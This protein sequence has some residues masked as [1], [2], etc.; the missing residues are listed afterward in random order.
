MEHSQVRFMY[1]PKKEN[2]NQWQSDYVD[3]SAYISYNSTESIT[4]QQDAGEIPFAMKDFYSGYGTYDSDDKTFTITDYT[5]VTNKYRWFTI[6]D[7]NYN[8]FRIESN[9]GTVITLST[10]YTFTAEPVTGRIKIILP[11]FSMDDII[12]I[13]MWKTDGN[14]VVP[15]DVANRLS[16]IGQIVSRKRNFTEQGNRWLLKLG[17][18]SELL[19]KDINISSY[20]IGGGFPKFYQKIQNIVALSNIAN[21]NTI[22]LQWDSNNPILKKDGIT[23]FPDI[24]YT[25]DS[26]SAWDKINELCQDK[27]TGDGEYYFYILPEEDTTNGYI[28]YLRAKTFEPD[29][30]LIEGVDFKLISESIAQTDTISRLV[31]KCG[32]DIRGANITTYIQG[33]LK[34][35]TRGKPVVWN[36]A[37]TIKSDEVFENSA[38]FDTGSGE[39]EYLYPTFPYT[40]YT[41]VT[42]EEAA[43]YPSILTVGTATFNNVLDIIN[44]SNYNKWIRWLSRARAKITG[45]DYI[46]KTNKKR[47]ML[48]IRYYNSPM[49]LIQGNV[50]RIKI[51]SIGWTGGIPG[52][53]DYRKVLRLQ[54]KKISIT[55]QGISIDCEYLE[56]W[57]V[58]D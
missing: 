48:S 58:T 51:P 23:A 41:S 2:I 25:T 56:D 40:T 52:Q 32:K 45:I 54:T 30:E 18:M 44:R 8:R 28:F 50:Y 6:Q 57:E 38:S 49:S 26:K 19:L 22:S 36:F 37:S 39:F 35:G 9:T 10:D 11:E 3:L 53:S 20:K 5:L 47:T 42:T 34:Y 46:N 43:Q 24:G 21:G 31:V 15:V 1:F 33:N 14:Y 17:N 29:G 55:E 4:K 7:Q 12:R 16:F 27:Y 13:E